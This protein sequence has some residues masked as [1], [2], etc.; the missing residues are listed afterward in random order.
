LQETLKNSASNVFFYNNGITIV[1]KDLTIN[2]D[3]IIL[4]EPQIVNGA[5]TSQTIYERLPLISDVIGS[6]QL[7]IIKESNE[8]TRRDI[9]KFRNS[10][11]SVKGKDLI[12]L[13]S[14]HSGIRLQLKEV[15]YYYQQQAGAWKFLEGKQSTHKGHEIFKK[16]LTEDHEN[17]IEASTAIQAMV[18]GIFQ[19]PT[20]PYSSIASYM[21]NGTNYS[22]VFDSKLK[23]DYRLLFY[24]YLIKCY[25]ERLGYGVE[26]KPEQKRYARLVFVTA[27]F[28]ILFDYILQKTPDVIKSNPSLLD[29]IFTNFENNNKLLKLTDDVVA[30]SFHRS[31]EYFDEHDDVVTWHNFFS[32]H[33][34]N[35]ELQKSFKLKLPYFGNLM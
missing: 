9:T 27:Y 22:K 29:P 14:F 2:D 21:P 31:S 17:M 19:N 8:T 33:A 25:G 35:D 1:V 7:T 6:I 20:K 15:G 34:W 16:Y 10:Q 24:P 18:A 11:N 5:Q 28:K 3:E 30:Y 32:H 4:V 13:E 12:S 23:E 26:K